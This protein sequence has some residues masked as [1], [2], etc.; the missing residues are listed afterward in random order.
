[1][2]LKYIIRLIAYKINNV[3]RILNFFTI[4]FLVFSTSSCYSQQMVQ[5]NIDAKKLKM[6]KQ[7]F[8]N[9]PLKILLSEIKPKIKNASGD[10]SVNWKVRPGFFRFQFVM[11]QQNDSL[12][13][14]GKMPVTIL[15]YVKENFDWDFKKREK[16]NEFSWTKKDEEKYGNLTV[17]GLRIYGEY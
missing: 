3:K 6:N 9:K 12:K 15:V 10:P 17:I 1:M 7:Q 2:V 14:V 16:R 13:A 8:I 4:T 5:T 11:Q